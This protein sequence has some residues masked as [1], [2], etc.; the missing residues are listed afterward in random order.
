MENEIIGQTLSVIAMALMFISYQVKDQK[1]LLIIQSIGTGFTAISFLFL[2]AMSAF[3]L[4]IVCIIRN[5][6]FYFQND[7][8]KYSRTIAVVLAIVMCSVGALSWQGYHSLLIIIALALNT[9]FMSY[10]DPQLLRKSIPFTS[11]LTMTHNIIVLSIGGICS[12]FF[13]IL[14]SIIGIIRYRKK[15]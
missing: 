2:N 14:S 12:E 9:F 13:S 15:Q 4:N 7:K 10:G 3:L 6:I 8:S 1:N 5:V 11:T